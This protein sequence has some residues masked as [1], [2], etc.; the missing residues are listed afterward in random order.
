M[1]Q[2]ST[3][4]SWFF[5]ACS[6]LS[7]PVGCRIGASKANPSTLRGLVPQSSRSQK[8][9]RPSRDQIK[10]QKSLCQKQCWQGAQIQVQHPYSAQG[11]PPS[12]SR[13]VGLDGA[14]RALPGTQHLKVVSLQ[15]AILAS[16]RQSQ[17]RCAP[18]S[19]GAGGFPTG[20]SDFRT[21]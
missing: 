9:T 6:E 18:R 15:L 8:N 1:K 5:F 21:P 17:L 13:A 10:I 16:S 20:Q 4:F 7:N 14:T 3:T 19:R 2:Y 11:L 12:L